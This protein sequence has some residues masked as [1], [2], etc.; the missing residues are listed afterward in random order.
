MH[1][2]ATFVHTAAQ[3]PQQAARVVYIPDLHGDPQQALAVLEMAGL[4][5]SV[6]S[7]LGAT[8]ALLL[9]TSWHRD[10]QPCACVG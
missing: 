4:I 6:R 8:C 2:G 10:F 7:N 5:S 3:H 1:G 9:D